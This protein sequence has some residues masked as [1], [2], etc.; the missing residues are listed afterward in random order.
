MTFRFFNPEL[1]YELIRKWWLSRSVEFFELEKLP[2]NGIIAEDNG[3]PIAAGFLYLTDSAFAIITWLVGNPDVTYDL[4]DRGVQAVIEQL[5]AQSKRHG[6]QVAIGLTSH[7]GLGKKYE[8][9]GFMYT[10]SVMQYMRHV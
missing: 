9:R 3:V 10:E 6:V 5:C 7:I 2:K 1:D 4:R 8:S